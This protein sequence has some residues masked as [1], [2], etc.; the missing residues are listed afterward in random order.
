VSKPKGAG[1]SIPKNLTFQ[2]VVKKKADEIMAQTGEKMA[3]MCARLIVEEYERKLPCSCKKKPE[4]EKQ[5]QGKKNPTT[6]KPVKLY[7][8]GN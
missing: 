6:E 2:P 8:A 3:V 7:H 4:Q 5:Q 1:R